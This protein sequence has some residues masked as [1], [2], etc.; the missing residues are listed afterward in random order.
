MIFA[1]VLG[2]TGPTGPERRKRNRNYQTPADDEP[3]VETLSRGYASFVTGHS[4][5][6]DW[7][8]ASLRVTASALTSCAS[9]FPPLPHLPRIP[10][11]C[12]HIGRV[13]DRL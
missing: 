8:R 3:H 13:L 9:Q 10:G 11:R 2:K 5:P 7:R 12:G 1:G 6:S 4:S